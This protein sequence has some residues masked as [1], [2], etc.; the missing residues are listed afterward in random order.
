MGRGPK[1]IRAHV[2]GDLVVVLVQGVLTA[3]E[4]QVVKVLPSDKGRDLL[5]QVRSHLVETARPVNGGHDSR[6]HGG[7]GSE[8][9]PRHQ[10]CVRRSSHP[11]HAGRAAEVPR[12]QETVGGNPP[13]CSLARM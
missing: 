8:P 7:E 9:A 5:K 13:T 6:S 10:H 11:L 3:A 4:K 2:L 1:D 12:R